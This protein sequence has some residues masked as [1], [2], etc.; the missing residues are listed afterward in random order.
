MYDNT[1]SLVDILKASEESYPAVGEISFFLGVPQLYTFTASSNSDV[2]LLTLSKDS[3]E[4]VKDRYPDARDILISN[5]RSS[6]SLGVKDGK[7]IRPKQSFSLL[8]GDVYQ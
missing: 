1:G 2:K 8:C 7:S 5:V 6:V 4:E 3:Y